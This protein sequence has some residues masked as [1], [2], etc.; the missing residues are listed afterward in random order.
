MVPFLTLFLT[1]TIVCAM[2]MFVL[3][4]HLGTADDAE[5]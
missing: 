4:V 2:V 1:F 5:E 3:G